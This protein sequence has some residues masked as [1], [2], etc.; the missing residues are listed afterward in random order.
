VFDVGEANW[1]CVLEVG[2]M[3]PINNM[4]YKIFTTVEQTSSV[5][6]NC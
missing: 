2:T 4:L 6:N 1:P 3:S 5:D